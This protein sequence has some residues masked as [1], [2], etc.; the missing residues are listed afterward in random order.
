MN[1]IRISTNRNNF[2]KSQTETLELKNSI[3]K[4]KILLEGFNRRFKQTEEVINEL[5]DI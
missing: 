3:T 2:K 4:L 5:T 1:K